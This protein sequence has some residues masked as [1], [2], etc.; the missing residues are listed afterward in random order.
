MKYS[1]IYAIAPSISQDLT[2]LR[3]AFSAGFYVKTECL[4]GVPPSR[5]P[6]ISVRNSSWFRAL[7]SNWLLSRVVCFAPRL[8]RC[9]KTCPGVG[10]CSPTKISKT[11]EPTVNKEFKN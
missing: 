3:K 9:A 2:P 4:E 5:Q 11:N 1:Y 10:K 6:P 7:P 8:Q